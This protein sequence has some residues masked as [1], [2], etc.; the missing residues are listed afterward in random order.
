M[1][2]AYEADGSWRAKLRRRA[3]RLTARRRARAPATPMLS[4]AFDDAPA[5]AAGAGAA[6]LAARGLKGSY[7]ICAGLAGAQGSMGRLA[8]ADAVRGL[9]AA[10]HE[11]GCHT[12]SHLDCGQAGAREAVDDVAR[13]AETLAAWGLPRPATFAYPYGDVAAGPKRALAGRFSLLRAL[14]HGLVAEGC[15]LNQA[16]AVGIE[17]RE[18]EAVARRWLARAERRRAW[19]ILYTHDVTPQ[20]SP[21]GCT[22]DALA[23]LADEALSAGFEVVTVAEGARRVGG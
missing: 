21:W 8:G 19:L 5:S 1:T 20:P 3:V 22:P 11:I 16:P 7:Y 18:G 9:A 23:R 4:I 10:G 13:N 15:D 12:F 2:E 14:H 6:I 17:G